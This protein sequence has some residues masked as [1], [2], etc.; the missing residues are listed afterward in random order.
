VERTFPPP[1]PVA[2]AQ[3]FEL[4]ESVIPLEVQ[5]QPIVKTSVEA[6]AAATRPVINRPDLKTDIAGLLASKSGLREAI[7]LREIFGPPP[8]LRDPDATL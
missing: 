6:Y 2:T 1:V 5:Q 8:G 4:H 7:I 3:A